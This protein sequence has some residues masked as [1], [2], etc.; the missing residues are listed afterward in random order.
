MDEFLTLQKRAGPAA[1]VKDHK[2]PGV[3]AIF[4]KKDNI[5]PGIDLPETN[6]VYIGRAKNLAKRNHFKARNSGTHS[7]RRS[8]GAILR[9][10]LALTPIHGGK[11]YRFS[12]E[13]EAKLT[14]WMKMNLNYAIYRTERE[15]ELEKELI[16]EKRPPLNL[17]MIKRCK[18]E[19][20]PKIKGLIEGCRSLANGK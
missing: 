7:P 12:N 8:L 20:A 1:E 10:E 15:K 16:L 17:T 3:Y 9:K 18:N 2:V 5:L 11:Y 13:D 14:D 19:Q 4:A 6:L